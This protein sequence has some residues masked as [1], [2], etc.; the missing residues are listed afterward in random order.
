LHGFAFR[1]AG[2]R[3]EDL[4]QCHGKSGIRADEA[5]G[6]P[7]HVGLTPLQIAAAR[8]QT[9]AARKVIQRRIA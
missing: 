2:Q 3:R 8:H 9:G 7:E 4:V 1:R 6:E 5:G